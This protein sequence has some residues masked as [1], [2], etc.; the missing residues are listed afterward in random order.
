MVKEPRAGWVKTRLAREIGTGAALRFYRAACANLIRRLGHDPRWRLV[1][2]VSPDRAVNSRAWPA[3]IPR[4]HQGPGDLGLRMGRLL[5]ERGPHATIIIGSDIPGIL[6][7]HIAQAFRM[8]GHADALFGPAADGGYWLVG[9]KP[10]RPVPGLFDT[11][12]WSS[13]YALGDTLANLDGRTVAFTPTLEDVDDAASLRR[14]GHL[15]MRVT[16]AR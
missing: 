11:V 6:P 16:P 12:R 8:L 4:I 1:L 3:G 7:S 9:M 2:A 5:R 14:I 13:P 10:D 15:G